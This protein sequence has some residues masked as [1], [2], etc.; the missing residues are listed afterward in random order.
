MEN[1]MTNIIKSVK[2]NLPNTN[3]DIIFPTGKYDHITP[4]PSRLMMIIVRDDDNDNILRIAIIDESRNVY[5]RIGGWCVN[6]FQHSDWE[7]STLRGF[8]PKE[9]IEIVRLMDAW[10]D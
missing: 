4:Q 5:R 8:E 6:Y 10:C 7:K 2:K 1:N 9:L 3:I